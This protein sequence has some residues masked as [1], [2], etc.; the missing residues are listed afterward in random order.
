MIGREVHALR[1][2]R[3]EPHDRDLL[4]VGPIGHAS[5]VALGLALARPG[6]DVTRFDG[7]GAALMHLGSLALI[8]AAAGGHLLHVVLGNGAH[9]CV[10]GQP[11]AARR[12]SL[13]GVADVSG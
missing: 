5:R 2:S 7:D 1:A 11:T 4:C 13:A 9:D 3:G 6:L 10:G 12:M 8:G